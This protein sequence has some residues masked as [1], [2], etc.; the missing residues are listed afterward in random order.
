MLRSRSAS[1]QIEHGSRLSRLPH[2]L[3]DRTARAASASARANGTIRASG[4]CS[5]RNTIRRALRCPN[6]GSRAKIWI[7]ASSSGPPKNS[8]LKSE[9]RKNLLF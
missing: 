3:Q 4:D 1:L 2:T 5:S 6:P 9:K 7:S 8:G